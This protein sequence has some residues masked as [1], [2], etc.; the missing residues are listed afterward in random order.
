MKAKNNEW[1]LAI[2]AAITTVTIV[3]VGLSLSFT[4]LSVRLAQAHY[5]ASAIGAHSVVASIVTLI[6]APFVPALARI[7]GV[8]QLLIYALL[9]GAFSLAAFAGSGGY[10]N[11]L[12]IRIVFSAAL[13]TL[14]VLSEFWIN[15]ASLPHKRGLVM[16]IYTTS[17][18]VGFAAGPAILTATGT[19]G[20]EPF[21]LAMVLFLI[22]ALPI[23]LVGAKAP[24]IEGSARMALPAF[25]AAAP[26]AALA[27]LVYG[28]VETAG[29][30]LLP[31]YALRSG[32]GTAT[33]AALAAIFSLGN[34]LFQTPVGLLSDRVD[35]RRLLFLIALV[36]TAGAL[37]LPLVRALSFPCFAVV[38]LVWGGI[39][40]SLYAVG[41][42]QLGAR[43]HGAKLASANA[44]YIMLYCTGT[45]LGPPLFGMGL[46]IAPAGLFVALA[47]ML[48]LYLGIA[49]PRPT[50]S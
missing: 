6:L 36:G 19:G 46:D 39:V 43:Y 37:L 11:W 17:I 16:G 27:A 29:M 2:G 10:W 23:G 30:G 34:A 38:L 9:T 1:A 45:L 15:S 3:G 28:A 25:V 26:A 22:A 8:R 24:I 41:L 31:V 4:L 47:V 7:I 42:A 14:F 33:G 13:T 20:I 5:S 18:A 35:R 49:W 21:V 50:T 48:A 44:S 12:I 32:L 40:G